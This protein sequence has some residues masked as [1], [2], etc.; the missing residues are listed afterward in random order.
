MSETIPTTPDTIHLCSLLQQWNYTPAMSKERNAA[1][2]AII[3][4]AVRVHE[5]RPRTVAESAPGE[6]PY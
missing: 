3:A 6:A 5:S 2:E 1:V 4:E